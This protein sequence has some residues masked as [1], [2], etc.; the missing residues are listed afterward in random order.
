MNL[1][2]S[3]VRAAGEPGG[4]RHRKRF[5]QWGAPIV[6]LALV[7]SLL[8]ACGGGEGDDE[9]TAIGGEANIES[10]DYPEVAT[11]QTITAGV[12]T[13]QEQYADPVI[14]NIGGNSYPIMQSVGDPLIF[15][16]TDNTFGPGL[17]ESW[18]TSEDGLTWTFTL[19]SGV[20]MHDGSDFTAKDVETSVNR[21][22]EYADDPAFVG[23]AAWVAQ[24]ESVKVLDDLHVEI[25]S[26]TPYASLGIA[27]PVPIATDYYEEVG[28][29]EFRKQPMAA[30][31]WMFDS[32]ILNDSMTL[33]RFDDY[34][35]ES[36]I[37]NF[38][39]LVLKIIPDESTRVSSL[40]SGQIDMAMGL[41][42]A[43]VAQLQGSADVKLVNVPD[44]A[45]AS[46]YLPDLWKDN[47][48]PATDQK[49]REAMLMAVDRESIANSLYAGMGHVP[50]SLFA[51]VAPGYDP[52]AEP[53][54]YDPEQA[55]KLLEEAGYP[56]GFEIDFTTYSQ[57]TVV[58]DVQKLV[59][60][61][62]G[63]WEQIGIKVNIN[64]LDAATYLPAVRSHSYDGAIVLGAP[65]LLYTDP[66]QYW[67]WFE[68]DGAYS[69]V[70]DPELDKVFAE[71]NQQVDPDKILPIAT[72]IRETVDAQHYGLPMV[73]VDTVHAVGPNVAQWT[74][75]KG[76]PYAGPFWYIN[77]K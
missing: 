8:T 76:N 47:G 58:P 41:S 38:E 42:P 46:V 13:L 50:N 6:L 62:A 5:R 20:K 68:S 7:V 37:A 72:E 36:R 26:K 10:S 15:R 63:Y 18:E 22:L 69:T 11:N 48:A 28:E 30:G 24:V 33:K 51:S 54:P 70:S 49:V 34:Y 39:T 64:V 21:V 19:R 73:N 3:D 77:A 31:P 1:R 35:D 12:S 2:F 66:A 43:S 56:D 59:E 23:Y 67:T 71:L 17:A 45:I 27:A 52:D 74:T 60:A 9:G 65:S 53:V 4:H 61:V 75:L 32:Q 40:Q 57:T 16:N 25:T 29:A 44:S 14:A 55:K